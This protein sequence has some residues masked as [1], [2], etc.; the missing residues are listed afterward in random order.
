MEKTKMKCSYCN[1]TK[2]RRWY[3]LFIPICVNPKCPSK[4]TDSVGPGGLGSSNYSQ[5]SRIEKKLDKLLEA[6]DY[7]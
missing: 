2:E 6:R 5:L 4:F 7:E 3:S 1:K